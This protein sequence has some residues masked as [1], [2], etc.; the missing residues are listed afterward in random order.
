LTIIV[1]L[2]EKD[3]QQRFTHILWW[4]NQPN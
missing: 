1:E 2:K 3:K 4:V